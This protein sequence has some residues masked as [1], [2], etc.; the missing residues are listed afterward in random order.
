MFVDWFGVKFVFV[1]VVVWW[2]VFMMVMSFVCGGVLLFGLCFLFGVGEVGVFL[3]VMKFVE[4][5]FL[6]IECGFV[7]GIYDCGVCGGILIVLLIC[8][9]IIIVY[10][11]CV[12]FIFIGVIGFVWVV[13]WLLVVSEFL[14]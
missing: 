13:V 1:G 9:V 10:G 5:W 8:I 3:F 4:C 11:W 6:L 12:L 2:L 7:F 14:L